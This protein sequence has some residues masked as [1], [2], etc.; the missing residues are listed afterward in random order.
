MEQSILKTVKKLVHIP[1]END[2]YDEDIILHINSAF[3]DLHQL[4]LG[5]DDD[6]IIENDTA[7]WDEYIGSTKYI[8]SVKTWVVL[9]VRLVFDPPATSFT[10]DAYQKQLDELTWRLNVQREEEKWQDPTL[11]QP[12][13]SG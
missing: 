13:L 3:S 7:T 10:I 2:E 12:S 4:G 9:K 8:Q 6:F 1:P 11:S 5:P